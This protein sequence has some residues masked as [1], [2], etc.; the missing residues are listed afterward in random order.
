MN[1]KRKFKFMAKIRK[2]RT[3]DIPEIHKMIEYIKPELASIIVSEKKFTFFPF[4]VLHDILPVN[5]KF[6][7]ECY[8]AVENNQLLGLIGL[9][10]DGKQKTRWRIDRLILNINSYETGKQLID[11]VV[12]KYGGAGVETF[13]TTMDESHAEAIALFKDGCGFRSC[14]QIHI[15]EKDHLEFSTV[16]GGGSILREVKPNDA[17][18]IQELDEQ[19]LFAHFRPSLTKN[20]SDFKFDI[21]SRL[22]NSCKGYSVRRLVLDNPHYSSI[23][24]YVLIM[25]RD[26]QE[27]QADIILSPFY[28]EYYE[29]IIKHVCN[30]VYY[31]N[32]GAMLNIY[33]RNYYQSSKKFSEVLGYLNFKLTKGFQVLARDYWKT[34]KVP[35]ED[36]KSPIIIFPEITSPACNILNM[37]KHD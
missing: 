30:Y 13:I 34:T 26:N 12:S 36:K 4:T 7:Q 23:E 32:N 15:W 33:V 25:T 5:M 3:T 27:F 6:L 21:K 35:L 20:V 8:V 19:S 37:K 22:I 10:P 28:Q 16:S 9:I 14:A 24:G 17:A 29:D 18:H 11:Y 1:K 2:L 31:Q